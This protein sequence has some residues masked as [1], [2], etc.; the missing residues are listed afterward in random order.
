MNML[1]LKRKSSSTTTVND[2]IDSKQKKMKTNHLNISNEDDNKQ[3]IND[4]R[5]I[6]FKGITVK[7]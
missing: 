7:T 2:Q 3:L 1:T 6:P 5:Q 4:C